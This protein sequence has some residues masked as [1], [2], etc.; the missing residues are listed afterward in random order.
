MGFVNSTQK[1]VKFFLIRLL[2]ILKI[3]PHPH[4]RVSRK[5]PEYLETY[6]SIRK[7]SRVF[8]TFPE[9]PET[10][11]SVR[12][13]FHSVQNLSRVYNNFPDYLQT[14]QS[15]WKLSRA[16]GGCYWVCSVSAP[17]PTDLSVYSGWNPLPFLLPQTLYTLNG[18]YSSLRHL[19]SLFSLPEMPKPLNTGTPDAGY[20]TRYCL[21]L[22]LLVQTNHRPPGLQGVQAPTSLFTYHIGCFLI[23]AGSDTT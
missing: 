18:A 1:S 13:V 4:P 5:M 22:A 21:G 23:S 19:F 12:K 8:R 6:E 11:Q 7:L 14:C 20:I 17:G 3:T 9:C 2:Q 16:M 15:V 10:F